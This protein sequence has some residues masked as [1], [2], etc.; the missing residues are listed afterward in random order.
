MSRRGFLCA[1][2]GFSASAARGAQRTPNVILIVADDLGYGDLGCYGS[3][4]PTP[5]LDRMAAEGARLTQFYSASPVC[6]PS[7]AALLT[8]RYPARSGVTRVLMPWDQIGLRSSEATI[9]KVLKQEG[10][11][12]MCIGKWHLGVRQDH[13]PAQHGFDS[14]YGLLYSNDMSPLPLMSNSRTI[15]EL[16]DQSNLTA[17]YTEQAV[18]FIT[19]PSE[20][21]FFLYLAHSM[22]HIPLAASAAFRGKSGLGTYGDAVMEMDWSVGQVLEALRSNGLAEN[23]LVVF[24]SDNGPWY[25]GGAGRLRGRKGSTFEGGVRV[26]FVAWMPGTIAAGSEPVGLASMMDLLPTVAALAGAKAPVGMDG[27]DIGTMLKGERS[28]IDRGVLLYFDDLHVQCARWGP[29]KLHLARYNSPAWTPDPPGGR[30]NLPL[31]HPELYNVVADP[32]EA[33]DLA[34]EKPEIVTQIREMVE[35]QLRKMPDDVRWAWRDTMAIRV[36]ETP[37]GAL[38]AVEN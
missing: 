20:Q 18:S 23:T 36:Q 22:P 38:P 4:I 12:T 19:A 15:E 13:L 6:S 8:G 7:R 16:R 24:T 32:S 10:Y 2:A 9:G 17:R 14:F 35:E 33:F 21:P 34:A 5:H 1:A 37:A 26:P 29:W 3:Q 30:K 27:V 11:R 25:Q 28:H 31:P